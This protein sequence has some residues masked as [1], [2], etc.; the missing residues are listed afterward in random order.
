MPHYYLLGLLVGLGVAI[1]IGPMNIEIIRRNLTYGL[2][3]GIIF[4]VG[5]VTADLT[6]FILLNL[7]VETLLTDPR[8][9][10]PIGII[11]SCILI[12]F[13]YK[14][15][16]MKIKQNTKGLENPGPLWKQTRDGYLLTLSSP[17][18]IL[19]WAS[20][21]STVAISGT[22]TNPMIATALGV[23]TGVV[24]WMLG[25]NGALQITRDHLPQ[26]AMYYLNHI[27]SII[28]LGFA[29]FGI[30]RSFH[31]LALGV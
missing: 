7:G 4:G 22:G 26:K 2:T 3:T 15:W 21:S 24:G 31:L 23:M 25:L 12:W 11:G 29:L 19:F 1:P 6:Y 9:I 27:G 18:T 17:L 16:T 5:I 30:W 10:F 14:A 13:A 20:M 28:L 8:I